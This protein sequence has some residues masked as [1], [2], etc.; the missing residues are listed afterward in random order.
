[1]GTGLMMMILGRIDGGATIQRLRLE[2]ELISWSVL[3][4]KRLVIC[5]RQNCF[6]FP[7]SFFLRSRL[8]S[9]LHLKLRT[10]SYLSSTTMPSSPAAAVNLL[11]ASISSWLLWPQ[12]LHGIF[13]IYITSAAPYGRSSNQI[14]KNDKLIRF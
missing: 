12:N 4:K 3:K 11:F 10:P 14:P 8:V 9:P 6:C 13:R 5:A 2:E 7:T 1:M